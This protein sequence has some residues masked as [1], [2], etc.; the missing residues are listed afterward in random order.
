MEVRRQVPDP[1]RPGCTAWGSYFVAARQQ[2]CVAPIRFF[3]EAASQGTGCGAPCQQGAEGFLRKLE[4]IEQRA[5]LCNF[6]NTACEDALCSE[7]PGLGTL[8]LPCVC[9]CARNMLK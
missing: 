3:R 4:L 6:G 1:R 5:W 9:A 8:V 2:A 7:K